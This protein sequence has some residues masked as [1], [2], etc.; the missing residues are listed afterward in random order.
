[1]PSLAFAPQLANA[2]LI[3]P[4]GGTR[5]AR[6]LNLSTASLSGQVSAW[7]RGSEAEAVRLKS[8]DELGSPFVAGGS[9]LLQTTWAFATRHLAAQGMQRPSRLSAASSAASMPRPRCQQFERI[10]HAAATASYVVNVWCAPNRKP[11]TSTSPRLLDKGPRSSE[12]ALPI[13]RRR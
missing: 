2:L 6:A 5:E 13:P 12:L 10:S 7:N 8:V 9:L 1:M 4:T 3:S 11:C